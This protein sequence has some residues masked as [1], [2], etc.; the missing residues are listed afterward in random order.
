LLDT[1]LIYQQQIFGDSSA[2]P[3]AA[4]VYRDSGWSV[5]DRRYQLGIRTKF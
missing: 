2:T 4:P 3:G 5:V 1:K